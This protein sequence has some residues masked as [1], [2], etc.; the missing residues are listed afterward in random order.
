MK[1]PRC[2]LL[3]IQDDP[4]PQKRV[5]SDTHN[6]NLERIYVQQN[7]CLS[8]YECEIKF[9]HPLGGSYVQKSSEKNC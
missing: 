3:V 9:Y 7:L 4:F 1:C 6:H 8:A 2:G 5:V